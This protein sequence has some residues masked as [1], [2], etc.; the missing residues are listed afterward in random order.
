[1]IAGKS[2]L[3]LERNR[4]QNSVWR[5]DEGTGRLSSVVLTIVRHKMR[6]GKALARDGLTA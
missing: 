1:M 3:G 4:G 5:K 2:L 6:E